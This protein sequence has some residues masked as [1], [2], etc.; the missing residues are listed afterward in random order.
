M[1]PHTPVPTGGPLR[2]AVPEAAGMLATCTYLCAGVVAASHDTCAGLSACC[3]LKLC[4]GGYSTASPPPTRP[5]KESPA[6]GR[7]LQQ[8]LAPLAL[9]SHRVPHVAVMAA[10]LGSAVIRVQG[11]SRQP[12]ALRAAAEDAPVSDSLQ[13]AA[14]V[15]MWGAMRRSPPAV[16]RALLSCWGSSGCTRFVSV[17]R[18]AAWGRSVAAGCSVLN[19]GHRLLLGPTSARR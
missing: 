6:Q 11:G 17:G 13:R 9:V 8:A 5:V 4:E 12:R 7:H 10:H 1:A 2:L 15:P 3:S 16:R 14:P 19:S 18:W